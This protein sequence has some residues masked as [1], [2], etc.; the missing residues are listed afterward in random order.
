ML[1]DSY[2]FAELINNRFKI[3][4]SGALD[5]DNTMLIN[6]PAILDT[7]CAYSVLPYYLL[8]QSSVYA[9][10]KKKVDIRNKVDYLI[11]YGVE[12]GGEHHKK[13]E[14]IDEL[15]SCTGLKFKHNL[16][17]FSL[18]NYIIGNTEIYVNYNR[19]SNILIGMD[20]LQN[21]DLHI[22][23]SRQTSTVVLIGILKE[24]KDRA[25]YNTAIKEHF[26]LAEDQSFFADIFRNFRR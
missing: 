15:M 19:K 26:G 22:G 23:L 18:N 12:T 16:I 11:S 4:I 21:F 1:T 10:A 6:Q 3:Y 7:G 8:V 5:I 14:T 25:G 20:I 17:N 2:L 13:P 24:Q 9:V